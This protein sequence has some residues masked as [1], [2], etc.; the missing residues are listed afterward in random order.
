[1]KDPS[2]APAPSWWHRFTRWFSRGKDR[3]LRL[4]LQLLAGPARGAPAAQRDRFVYVGQG[5][6]YFFSPYDAGL[7][8]QLLKGFGQYLEGSLLDWQLGDLVPSCAAGDLRVSFAAQAPHKVSVLAE[9][10][11]P[12]S[13]HAA[14]ADAAPGAAAAAVDEAASLAG[15]LVELVPHATAASGLS[16]GLVHRGWRTPGEMLADEKLDA[17]WKASWPRFVLL[18]L[19]ALAASRLLLMGARGV[20]LAQK[21]YVVAAWLP[22]AVGLWAGVLGTVGAAVW[23]AALWPP[24]ALLLLLGGLALAVQAQRHA[25]PPV[26]QAGWRAAWCLLARWSGLPPEWRVEAGYAGV[27]AAPLDDGDFSAEADF[28]S[29]DGGDDD[30]GAAVAVA[31]E[32]WAGGSKGSNSWGAHRRSSSPGNSALPVAHAVA[33]VASENL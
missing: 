12:P 28:L 4:D 2:V 18:P 11:P 23:P 24:Y 19:W 25:P 8:E 26:V 30:A 14:A 10:A 22:A 13:A 9:V 3:T 21:G 6:G 16:V 27:V 1:M 17:W 15:R 32:T 20:D 33:M 5:S 31:S 7:S 29:G